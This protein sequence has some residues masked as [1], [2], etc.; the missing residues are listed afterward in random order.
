MNAA[1][2]CRVAGLALLAVLAAG[3]SDG[4]DGEIAVSPEAEPYV[5]SLSENLSKGN[6]S[7]LEVDDQ[8]A[9]CIAPKWINTMKPDRLRKAGIKPADL[10]TDD[11]DLLVGLELTEDEGGALVDAFGDCGV[12]IK[13]SF[14]A[15]D[16]SLDDDDRACLSEAISDDLL[17]EVLIV[18]FTKGPLA[19]DQQ[20]SPGKDFF[21]AIATCPGA[22]GGE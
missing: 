7:L 9:A 8:Q 14:L 4:G 16:D 1:K 19:I 13:S 3:C 11:S 10:G 17:R 22:T 18:G 20:S 5:E 2:T 15:S 6:E 12:D 21:A